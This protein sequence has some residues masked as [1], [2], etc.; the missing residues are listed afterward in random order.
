MDKIDKNNHKI[1]SLA[2]GKLLLIILTAFFLR[3]YHLGYHNL[4]YDEVITLI[5]IS[6]PNILQIWNPPLYYIILAGW[7]K[8]FGFS[9]VSLRFPSLLFSLVCV[10]VIYLLGKEL[11]NKSAGIFASFITALSPFQLWYAQEARS[12]SLLV[13]L[14]LL[15]SY[16]QYLFINRGQ[17]KFLYWCIAFAIL[18]IYTHPYYILFI[19]SQLICCVICMR[20]RWSVKMLIASLLVPLSFIPI[21]QRSW[22]R[23]S[24]VMKNYWISTPSWKSL[25]ISIENFNLGYNS[26]LLT[27]FTFNILS[28]I[29]FVMAIWSVKKKAISRKGAIFCFSLF[30]LPLLFALTF[31]RLII[32][33]YFDRGL[34]ISTPFYYLILGLGI[35]AFRKK[36]LRFLVVIFTFFLVTV[37]VYGFVKDWMPTDIF[38]HRGVYLKKP[39]KPAVKF[40]EKNSG[41]EDIIA[42]THDSVK[43]PFIWYS[44]GRSYVFF[45]GYKKGKKPSFGRFRF[46]FGPESVTP[47]YKQPRKES[48]FN[49]PLVKVSEL[50]FKKLFVLAC[51][52]PRSGSLDDNSSTVK[53]KLDEIF[54]LEMKREFDGLWV[55]VYGK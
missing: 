13:F 10:P 53:E 3:L 8:I 16:F 26:H 27:Y 39:I 19:I 47:S 30:I 46:I 40:I 18:G 28:L 38:H 48:E 54:N 41:P 45:G 22:I 32:P 12:Y 37:G 7:V 9:E 11:F 33:I 4:W 24:A 17:N 23:L 49:V 44:E 6:S 21:M 34:I 51:D 31:S 14:G 35:S 1:F 20:K 15:S 50:E 36:L 25:L 55:Y 42:F 5:K 52:W 29:I 43:L 2:D